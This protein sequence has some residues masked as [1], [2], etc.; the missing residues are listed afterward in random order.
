[1]TGVKNT[2]VKEYIDLC[3]NSDKTWKY[4]QPTILYQIGQSNLS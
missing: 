3:V 1:M 4:P 2:E